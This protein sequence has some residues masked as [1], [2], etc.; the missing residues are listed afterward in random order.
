MRNGPPTGRLTGPKAC[1]HVSSVKTRLTALASMFAFTLSSQAVPPTPLWPA[2]EVPGAR[3]TDPVKDVPALTAY[4]ADP[5]SATG[6]AVVVCPGGGYGGLADHEGRDY[7]LWLNQRGISA[8]VLKYRLGSNGYR[9]PAMMRDVQR[10]VR[11]VRAQ[12]EKLGVDPARIGVMGSS[13]GG[14]LT[15]TAVTLFAAGDPDSTDPVERVS[16]R[17][18]FGILC[19]PVVSMH[20]HAHGGSRRNLLGEDPS[21][22]LLDLLSGELQVTADTPP[23]FIWHTWEDPAVDVENS[24]QF[25][26]ALRKHKVPF[27]LH[28]YQDGVH[29]IGLGIKGY[30]PGKSVESKLHPWTAD[31][32]FWLRQRGWGR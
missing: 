20:I 8:F 23:C 14:H 10:A 30:T 25:A 12:A 11:T 2:G 28:V 19:Y 31:L 29:G 4:P 15:S 13:A 6:A 18:D 21:D 17:P 7:A 1:P 22:E 26:A 9:H 5:K 27:D 32:G 3:G 16:S 24:L